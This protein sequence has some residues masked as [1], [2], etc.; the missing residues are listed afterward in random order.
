M[1]PQE[2]YEE[3]LKLSEKDQATFQKKILIEKKGI[4]E[5]LKENKK[6]I[7][8][9]MMEIKGSDGNAYF[10]EEFLKNKLGL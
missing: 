7:F 4:Q 3:Y 9:K 2:L 5:R 8:K 1:T 6:E 10:K